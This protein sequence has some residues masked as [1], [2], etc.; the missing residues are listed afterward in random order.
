MLLL[1]LLYFL[2]QFKYLRNNVGICSN[3]TYYHKIMIR[4]NCKKKKV[5]NAYKIQ[6]IKYS[7]ALL[8]HSILRTK[9]CQKP[10][11]PFNKGCKLIYHFT[12]E[13]LSI[14]PIYHRHLNPNSFKL[15][16]LKTE[17]KFIALP[18]LIAGPLF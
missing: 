4:L 13:R 18:S 16:H 12:A 2:Q 10:S 15:R 11:S 17:F 9:M 7:Q 6:L 5:R 14:A 3:K 8:T 1:L